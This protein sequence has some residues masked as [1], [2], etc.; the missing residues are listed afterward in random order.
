MRYASA[1]FSCMLSL[2]KKS[3]ILPRAYTN[4]VSSS[5][6]STERALSTIFLWKDSWARN[7]FRPFEVSCTST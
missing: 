2:S 5:G 7:A 6:V 3:L 4:T 1:L